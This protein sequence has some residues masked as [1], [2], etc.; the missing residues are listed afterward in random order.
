MRMHVNTAHTILLGGY[1]PE[2][3]HHAP[4]G[5]DD[6]CPTVPIIP[7]SCT[8]LSGNHHEIASCTVPS[9][10]P[11]FNQRSVS[12][13]ANAHIGIPGGKNFTRQLTNGADI[14]NISGMGWN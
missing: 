7:A 9:A 6:A 5:L 14:I 13:H 1:S 2:G 10:L 3:E 4:S 12:R 8:P 11:F